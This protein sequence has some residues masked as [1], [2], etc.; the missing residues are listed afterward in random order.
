MDFRLPGA[1]VAAV[2][3]LAASTWCATGDAPGRADQP[4]PPAPGVAESTGPSRP[5]SPAEAA[6]RANTTDPASTDP[7]PAI[8]A[9]VVRSPNDALAM[10]ER[11]QALHPE[12]ARAEERAWLTVDAL[13]NA[14]QIGRARAAAEDFLRRYPQSQHAERIRALTG[15]HPRPLGPRE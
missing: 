11:E 1:L 8:R 10:L 13:V 14:Q 4:L 12:D 3:L 5:V 15:V 9:A 7:M 6:R 2:V